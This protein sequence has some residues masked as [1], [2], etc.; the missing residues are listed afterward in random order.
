MPDVSDAVDGATA[1]EV[2]TTPARRPAARLLSPADVLLAA[3]RGTRYPVGLEP[4]DQN[5]RGGFQLGRV[6]TVTGAPFSGK[7]TLLTQL[8]LGLVAQGFAGAA[9]CADEGSFEAAGRIGQMLGLDRDGLEGAEPATIAE[10]SERTAGAKVHL[11]D[12]DD[13]ATTVTSMAEALRELYP[14]DPLVFLFDSVQTIRLG[15]H[16]TDDPPPTDRRLRAIHVI[17]GIRR[18]SRRFRAI[19]LVVSQPN[20]AAYASPNPKTRPNP[21][22]FAAEAGQI[23]LA[24]DIL[25]VTDRLPA[26]PTP[27]SG[28]PAAQGFSEDIMRLIAV[29]NRLGPPGRWEAFFRHDPVTATYTPIDRPGIVSPRKVSEDGVRAC[30]NRI[31]AALRPGIPLSSRSLHGVVRGGAEV[32]YAALADLE[33]SG[34]VTK[35]HGPKRA[36]LYAAAV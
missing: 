32:F 27:S 12:P 4:V 8:F 13:P 16:G 20:R 28:D 19:S 5:T 1:P 26:P 22:A 9:L 6:I 30:S 34:K 29:K 24:S 7:T 15:D 3:P 25:A 10:L 14:E 36:T 21:M 17:E 35:R 31:L 2:S 18:L 23:E 11:V 33:G